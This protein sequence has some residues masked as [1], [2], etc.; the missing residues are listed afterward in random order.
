MFSSSYI[1]VAGLELCYIN[2]IFSFTL[3]SAAAIMLL[4]WITWEILKQT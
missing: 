2:K 4:V 3:F 1:F